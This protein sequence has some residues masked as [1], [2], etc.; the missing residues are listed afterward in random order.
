MAPDG[1]DPLEAAFLLVSDLLF[2]TKPSA[3]DPS[4]DFPKVIPVLSSL[5]HR[6][7]VKNELLALNDVYGG[8]NKLT[9]FHG[10][11]APAI[12]VGKYLERIF[13][14]A[15]CSPSCFVVAYIYIDRLVSQH[16][17]LPITSLNIHRLLITTVMVAAKFHD[18]AYYNN[19]Y[20]AKVGGV[21]TAEMNRLE[22][23]VLFRVDFRLH[24]TSAVF[25]S[26]CSHLQEELQYRQVS[27]WLAP[28]P[29]RQ[30]D[31]PQ[32]H[33]CFA[34]VSVSSN[35]PTGQ[36]G[37]LAPAHV[38]AASKKTKFWSPMSDSA[39]MEIQSYDITT[40]PRDL[41]PYNRA[42]RADSFCR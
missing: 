3:F 37:G 26:Y 18:D 40:P 8:T 32:Q 27:Y 22:L 20:Y 41:E 12:S 11:R 4:A 35:Q 21:T 25:Y 19:A 36:Q 42:G 28:P 24:V 1:A 2:D 6:L 15:N 14:Y 34:E 39:P 7:V 10:L 16:P 5:L 38:A 17:E 23:E 30:V 9:A 13:K 31:D 33:A 29:L